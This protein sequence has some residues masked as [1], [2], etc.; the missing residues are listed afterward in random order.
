MNLWFVASILIPRLR[1]NI[2][3]GPE[4]LPDYLHLT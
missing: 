4:R 1:R 2:Y 3:C